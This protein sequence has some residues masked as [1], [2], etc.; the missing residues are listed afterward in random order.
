MVENFLKP[1]H[2]YTTS[3]VI[4]ST[5]HISSGEVNNLSLNH[6]IPLLSFYSLVPTTIKKQ[7]LSISIQSIPPSYNKDI[8]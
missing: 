3:K 6:E 1:L 5:K 7:P 2:Y 8:F 4:N